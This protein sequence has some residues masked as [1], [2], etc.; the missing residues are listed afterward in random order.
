MAVVCE[1]QAGG[2]TSPGQHGKGRTPRR[3]LRGRN[4]LEAIMAGFVAAVAVALFLVV[5]IGLGGVAISVRREDRRFTLV[6][7]APDLLS[8]GT[9]RLTGVG[10]RGLGGL[11]H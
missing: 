3:E 9:R 1:Y 10:R 4:A 7:E 5:M 6:G 11:T 2:S 8:R